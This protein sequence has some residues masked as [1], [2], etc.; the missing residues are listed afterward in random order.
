M[1]KASTAAIN[2]PWR[3]GRWKAAFRLAQSLY[4]KHGNCQGN[5]SN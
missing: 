1:D 2:S 5:E 3:Q 4:Q